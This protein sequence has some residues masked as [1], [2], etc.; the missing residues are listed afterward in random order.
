M[1]SARVPGFWSELRGEVRG[2]Q[3]AGRGVD[4]ERP[5]PVL[6]GVGTLP[7]RRRRGGGGPI[8][9]NTRFYGRVRI[10]W[11]ARSSK[12]K[13]RVSPYPVLAP[14]VWFYEGFP[15]RQFRRVTPLGVVSLPVCDQIVT[16]TR[17]AVRSL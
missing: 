4:G 15:A 3:P 12:L 8:W 16:K 1:D 2:V 14:S 7:R 6:F 10:W 11:S 9:A 13:R 17:S 5:N